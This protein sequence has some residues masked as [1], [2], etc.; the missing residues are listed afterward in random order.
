MPYPNRLLGW[1]DTTPPPQASRV[2]FSY[3]I[4]AP[5]SYGAGF[6]EKIQTV[7]F[8][9]DDPAIC[10]QTLWIPDDVG[11]GDDISRDVDRRDRGFEFMCHVVYKIFLKL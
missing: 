2:F 5:A 4:L 7:V 1:R 3:K 11:V 8:L 6:D 9:L 10:K